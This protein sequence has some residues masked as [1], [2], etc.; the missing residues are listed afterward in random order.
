MAAD[1][2]QQ[3]TT[4][5]EEFNK[6]FISNPELGQKIRNNELWTGDIEIA[7]IAE[8]LKLKIQ[9]YVFDSEENAI[10]LKVYG[11]FIDTDIP[12]ISIGFRPIANSYDSILHL[13]ERL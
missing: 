4:E 2:F 3:N 8:S 9:V 6:D 12:A 1:Y 7:S 11:E 5:F 13:E 10:L